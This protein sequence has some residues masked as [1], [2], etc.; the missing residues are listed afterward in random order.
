MPVTSAQIVKASGSGLAMISG[1]GVGG[2]AEEVGDLIMNGE[3]ALGL[4]G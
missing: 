1:V 2:T 4:P 3:K